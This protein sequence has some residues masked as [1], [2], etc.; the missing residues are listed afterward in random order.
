MNIRALLSAAVLSSTLLLAACG[1]KGPLLPPPA[2][3]APEEWPADGPPAAPV[4]AGEDAPAPVA[5]PVDDA[6]PDV[7]GEGDEPAVD[8]AGGGGA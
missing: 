8:D 4:P 7:D 5:D 3:E 1:N 6:G 2:P